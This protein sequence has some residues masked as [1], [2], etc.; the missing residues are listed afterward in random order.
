MEITDKNHTTPSCLSFESRSALIM[1]PNP[2]TKCKAF[3]KLSSHQ[4]PPN[5]LLSAVG[6]KIPM[7]PKSANIIAPVPPNNKRF[8]GLKICIN[9]SKLE[10]SPL[11]L[12]ARHSFSD[13]GARRRCH[14]CIRRFDFAQGALNLL[15]GRVT[16]EAERLLIVHIF[17]RHPEECSRRRIS[18]ILR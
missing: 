17:R 13:G 6:P 10:G 5:K 1:L 15:N 7:K 14:E 18:K 2:R 9:V 3:W 4:N 12:L 16:D 11:L 8:F